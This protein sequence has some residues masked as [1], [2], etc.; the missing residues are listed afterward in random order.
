MNIAPPADLNFA[1]HLRQLNRDRQQAL[2]FIDDAGTL[3]YGE[4]FDG[5]SRFGSALLNHGL[6]PK[7]RVLIAL[8][9]C[10]DWP[11]AFLG[12]LHAGLVPV[13]IN[14]LLTADD[15]AYLLDHSE[16]AAL[17]VGAKLLATLQQAQRLA[18]SSS[19]RCIVVG[20]VADAPESA[21][22]IDFREFI[23]SGDPDFAGATTSRDSVAFWLYSSGSTG[24]PKGV[25]HTHA[26]LFWTSE[27]YAKPILSI[28]QTDR[29]FSAAK[30]FFAYG[31][32][33]ALT[34]PLSVG[35]CSILMAE[36]PTPQAVLARWRAHSPTVFCAAPTLYASLLGTDAEFK[37]NLRI[38]TSAGEALPREV[39]MQFAKRFG[40]D[41]IDGLG[42]TE[43]LHIFISNRPTTVCYGTT[44]TPVEGY[45][46]EL[47][48]ESGAV[49][50]KDNQ[51]GDLWVKG[52][53]AA[54]S[55]W[56][57]SEKT[58]ATFH[59]EWVRT[60]DKYSR[61]EDGCFVYAGRNDDMLKISGQ[62][63][64]P[65]EVESSLIK[66]PAIL[67]SGVVAVVDQWG[68]QKSKAYVVLRPGKVASKELASEI[69]AYVKAMLAPFKRP[70]F[71][72]F[73]DELPKTATGK[74]QR[75]RLREWAAKSAPV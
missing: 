31:L 34:F 25:M 12:A 63:V 36:R 28:A 42:S 29:V 62:Y 3:T 69:Q 24:R 22:T 54:R 49:I 51:I 57:D 67:E 75:F 32:G 72:E 39:G 60:G 41:I 70:H 23:T 58:S 56:N 13:P 64:S 38:C 65:F 14:T 7:Q 52:P 6:K 5:V 27:L 43:M 45:E 33:N 50:L 8:E 26:N 15:Y 46:V 48:D 1:V 10:N 40:V 73:V 17:V 61:R 59:G 74:I 18:H 16:A 21:G 47:R 19:C 37:T 30:L 20:A 35:A 53:S 66:H 71:I 11:V 2:A 4:L 44:G 68:I 9:D 55:Y